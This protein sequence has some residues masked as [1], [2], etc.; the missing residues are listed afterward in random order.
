MCRSE[1]ARKRALK[2]SLYALER[3]CIAGSAEHWDSPT[4]VHEALCHQAF[5]AW[6]KAFDMFHK[7]K[8][9][10]TAESETRT[11]IEASKPKKAKT[12]NPFSYKVVTKGALS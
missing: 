3:A 5:V 9:I 4:E 8:A 1:R 11:A 6:R 10:E 12:D 2:L 7:A